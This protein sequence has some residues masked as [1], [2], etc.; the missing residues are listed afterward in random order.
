MWGQALSDLVADVPNLIVAPQFPVWFIPEDDREVEG[1]DS[2]IGDDP[3]EVECQDPK[4][5]GAVHGGDD[6]LGD[7]E[8]QE[9]ELSFA[10]T[11]PENDAKTALVDFA[12]INVNGEPY[13]RQ[14]SR[15]GGWK[16][17]EADVGV[18]VEIKRFTSRSLTG[19][20]F[21]DK[22]QERVLEAR[23]DLV[24][25]AAYLFIQYPHKDYVLAIAASGK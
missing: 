2:L 4:T 12:L 25:K 13:K 14:K 18:L 10:L 9:L 22:L 21:E 8:G 11:V 5:E 6:E 20:E 19:Y 3:E 23:D 7:H 16:I 1:D 24:V 15:Y 17:T